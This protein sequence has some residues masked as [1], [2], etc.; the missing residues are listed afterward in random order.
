[1]GLDPQRLQILAALVGTDNLRGVDGVGFRTGVKLLRKWDGE[2]L[3]AYLAM[4]LPNTKREEVKNA[5]DG[6]LSVQ[7]SITS[8]P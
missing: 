2:D 7:S 6:L 4:Q 5:M 1:L 8:H 3:L